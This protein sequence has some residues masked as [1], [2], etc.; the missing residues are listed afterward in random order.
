MKLKIDFKETILLLNGIP[1]NSINED[2]IKERW[3]PFNVPPNGSNGKFGEMNAQAVCWLYCWA[4]TGIS[5]PQAQEYSINAFN[6]I[7][8]LP[9]E[10]YPQKKNDDFH[11]WARRIR[12]RPN[13]DFENDLA[14]K[15]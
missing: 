15:L 8:E 7:F 10:R 4:M 9:F 5:S 2:V 14:Q 11:Q 6:R 3:I 13:G 12:Y 1:H